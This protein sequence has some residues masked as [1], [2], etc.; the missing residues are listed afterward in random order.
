MTLYLRL[1]DPSSSSD[2][3]RTST[4]IQADHL[5]TITELSSQLNEERRLNQELKQELDDIYEHCDT[6]ASKRRATDVSSMLRIG[7]E[8]CSTYEFVQSSYP[9]RR[10]SGL[11]RLS[12][13]FQEAR[14]DP[15]TR[16]LPLIDT[17]MK[18]QEAMLP[19]HGSPLPSA[20]STISPSERDVSQLSRS[21]ESYVEGA[22]LS[23]RSCL[24]RDIEV[25]HTLS[26]RMSLFDN[27]IV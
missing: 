22:S 23:C 21:G 2:L 27:L 6:C 25:C 4:T 13:Q 15:F 20:Q 18:N 19:H 8:D 5:S 16:S 26:P 14:R 9:E 24:L 7:S 10:I 17:S 1:G 3:Y 12:S 11:L